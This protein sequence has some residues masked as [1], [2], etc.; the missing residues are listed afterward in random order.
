MQLVQKKK[1]S[2]RASNAGTFKTKNVSNFHKF[3]V[4]QLSQ[5]IYCSVTQWFYCLFQSS[6]FNGKNKLVIMYGKW[7]KQ[8][9][10]PVVP[11]HNDSFVIGSYFLL[12]TLWGQNSGLLSQSSKMHLMLSVFSNISKCQTN[13][14][15]QKSI[16]LAED[17]TKWCICL[18]S[19]P[20]NLRPHWT[21]LNQN[22]SK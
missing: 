21:I 18:D 9:G 12:R 6:F 19:Q 8:A 1:T 5:I 10:P 3:S 16:S 11:R 17:Q 2:S 22:V 14:W 7:N 4:N 20:R 13:D 15:K